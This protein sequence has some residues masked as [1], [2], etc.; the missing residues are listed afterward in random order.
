MEGAR[1]ALV[2]GN[3]A[4]AQ[5]PLR[6]PTNDARAMG[7]RLTALGFD[8]T[9]VVDADRRTLEGAII[10][11]T[12]KLDED[13]AGLFYY[14]GHGLQLRGRNYLVPVDAAF[15]HESEVRIQAV[16]VDL[17][18]SEMEWAGNRLNIVILDAC[19]NNPFER[20]FRGSA[21]RGLAAIDAARGTLIAYATAPGAVA[22]DGSGDNGLYTRELLRALSVPGLTAEEVFKRV[23]IGVARATDERQIPWESSSLT[24]DFVFHRPP[25]RRSTDVALASTPAPS[26][27][28]TAHMDALFWE[29]I[30]DSARAADYEAYLEQFPRGTFAVLAR[31][32][33]AE[34]GRADAGAAE[35]DPSSGQAARIEQLL[36]LAQTDLA[37][38]RLTSP[39]GNNA[40][41]KLRQVLS[42]EPDNVPARDG[43]A[44]VLSRYLELADNAASRGQFDSAE[45]YIAKAQRVV[46]GTEATAPARERV[47][48]AR[49]RA[50]QELA[51]RRE[52]ERREQEAAA[53]AE[54]AAIASRHAEEFTMAGTRSVAESPA[55]PPAEPA[56][57]RA[58]IIPGRASTDWNRSSE[59]K[60]LGRLQQRLTAETQLADG[61]P[62]IFLA[63][64]PNPYTED[65][66]IMARLDGLW[67]GAFSTR[68]NESKAF[69]TLEDLDLDI[70]VTLAF[71][72]TWSSR[73]SG[74]VRVFIIDV[75]G[76]RIH[77]AS[78]GREQLSE[79]F[80]EA[81]RA[82]QA[83]AGSHTRASD[84]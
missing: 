75:K 13:T 44:Q 50:A 3:A 57:L 83:S 47:R 51:A 19:R 37:A 58:A 80:D 26:L 76:R 27:P 82:Y 46:P 15:D 68:I 72:A 11:F 38:L 9:T 66:G 14:A 52:A 17:V 2:V 35:P 12:R 56:R 77:E 32:R 1:I 21:S 84:N 79:A 71:W 60:V 4:Y 61:E 18:L 10:E 36:A 41:E 70:G 24:G 73:Q 20:R 74:T 53:A 67:G 63:H 31:N 49:A 8:V 30:K 78:A 34:L 39:A 29:S 62:D 22:A 33:I 45:S 48:L 6:N 16:D 40:V 59:T 25:A 65:K 69:A 7:A 54:K 28:P 42:L 64:Y 43:L 5:A 23:R 81:W 55:S